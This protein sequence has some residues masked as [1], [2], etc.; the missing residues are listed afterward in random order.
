MQSHRENWFDRLQKRYYAYV[1]R[2][3][4]ALFERLKRDHS[5]Q[6]RLTVAKIAAFTLAMSVHS[7]TFLLPILAIAIIVTQI[8]G[9]CSVLCG[10]SFLAMAVVVRP[11]FNK[12]PTQ[13]ASQ[14]KFPTL[15]QQVD[16]IANLLH[17]P[18]IDFIVIN[19]FFTASYAR[20]GLRQSRLLTL[21]HPLWMQLDPAERA[22]LIVHEIAHG[23]NGDFARVFVI[24]TAM[25]SLQRWYAVL[26][27]GSR[28][29][30]DGLAGVLLQ[31]F[32]LLVGNVMHLMFFVLRHLL[33][34]ESRRA[35]YLAD[36]LAAT[37]AGSDATIS[38][39]KK[40]Q[41]RV[42]K[43]ISISTHPP[44]DYRIAMLEAKPIRT[45]IASFS[46]EQI[47]KL[48]AE[49]HNLDNEITARIE[50]LRNRGLNYY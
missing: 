49:M 50:Q 40:I 19:E 17:A 31:F 9:Y 44:L 7:I 11:R 15:Y 42:R 3:D 23:V 21:G 5:L 46:D 25:R 12:T 14:E 48:D 8:A 37:V 13:I 16:Q 41:S 36:H 22:A 10:L 6:P 18:H 28:S 1:E 32:S 34:L 2:E 4:K 39:L 47:A 20:V 27:P 29:S 30:R 43:P 24:N 26:Y 38:M 45:A 35:E 33:L